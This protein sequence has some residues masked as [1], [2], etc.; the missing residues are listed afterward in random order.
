VYSTL[1]QIITALTR[2]W[3][4]FAS[5]SNCKCWWMRDLQILSQKVICYDS[6]ISRL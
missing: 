4:D 6:R 2:N 5:F 1:S 3:N